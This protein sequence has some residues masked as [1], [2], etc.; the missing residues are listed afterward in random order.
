MGRDG[1]LFK[2]E[3][4]TEWTHFSTGQ[5]FEFIDFPIHSLLSM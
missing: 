1:N 5:Y 2:F 4:G 3:P